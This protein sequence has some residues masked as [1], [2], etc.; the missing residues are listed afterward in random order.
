[1]ATVAQCGVE[2]RLAR[3]DLEY[4]HDFGDTDRPVHSGRS[5][6]L[7]D[8]FCHIFRIL[9]RLQ[10]FVFFFESLRVCA[11]VSYAPFRF[12]LLIIHHVKL[13]FIEQN[14]RQRGVWR[15]WSCFRTGEYISLY[16]SVYFLL[17]PKA[18]STGY[19]LAFFSIFISTALPRS[20]S[21]CWEMY[22]RKMKI[23][24]SSSAVFIL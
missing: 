19:F 4:V 6:S 18:L 24:A 21:K 9:F 7:P 3:N 13:S 2:S 12:W 10:L 23:S 22:A 11:L 17:L 14:A 15:I 16:N 5:S 1:M 20:I 8:H